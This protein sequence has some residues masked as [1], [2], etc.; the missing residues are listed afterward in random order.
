MKEISA[1]G[2]VYKQEGGEIFILM[3]KDRYSTWSLPKGKR[4]S[5]ET[6]EQTALR[7]ILEETG[8]EG[9][10]EQPLETI[11]YRYFHPDYGEVEKEVHYFLVQARAGKTVPQ[12]SEITDVAWLSPQQAWD[13]GAGGEVIILAETSNA[14]HGDRGRP[15]S[16][17]PRL[18]LGE[19]KAFGAKLTELSERLAGQGLKPCYHH[20]MGTVVQSEADI[21][22]L[23]AYTRPPFHLLLDSGHARWGGAD[24]AGLARTYRE[25]IGHVHCKDLAGNG[26]PEPRRRLELPRSSGPGGRPRRLHRPGR[27]H[28]RLRRGVP[29]AEGLFRLG[30]AG[31]RAGSRKY[32]LSLAFAK[33]GIAHLR[34]KLAEA[35]PRLA[36]SQ[37]AIGAGAPRPLRKTGYTREKR[38]SRSSAS[39]RFRPSV[40]R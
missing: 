30:G 28:G 2:V 3:I 4:E 38:F 32:G 15:L 19:W 8:V 22:R 20:H 11:F 26:P 31:G 12:L 17:R 35:G 23:M 9:E 33:R 29:G 25:R 13:K 21:D 27:R 18:T 16:E 1:G 37:Q 24:P 10:I 34:A 5:G 14:I 40:L 39:C 6:N 36:R 7:E